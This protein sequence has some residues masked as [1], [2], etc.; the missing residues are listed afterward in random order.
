LGVFCFARNNCHVDFLG[1]YQKF[2]CSYGSVHVNTRY[3]LLQQV[4]ATLSG[5]LHNSSST[6][7]R[8]ETIVVGIR[9]GNE[10]N[11]F[12][13]HLLFLSPHKISLMPVHGLFKLIL[14]I[15]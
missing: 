8:T 10:T 14:G 11:K 12:I 2:S 7:S 4:S 6:I 15:V 5:G 3:S 9:C 13:M 1:S